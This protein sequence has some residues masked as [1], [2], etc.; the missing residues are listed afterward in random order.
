MLTPAKNKAFERFF[1]VYNRNLFRRR[2]QRFLVEG[3][4]HLVS[5]GEQTPLILYANHSSWWDGLA[6]F[7]ISRAVGLDAFVMM[8]ETQLRRYR[9]FRRLGAFSIDKSS[10]RASYRSLEF[11]SRLLRERKGSCLWI[12]PQGDIRPSRV[13]DLD[14]LG[15]I[16]RIALKTGKCRFV[17]V[18]IRYE[19]GGEFKPDLY[20]RAG[21]ELWLEPKSREESRELVSELEFALTETLAILDRR[22]A[23]GDTGSF[24]DILRR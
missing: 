15:G 8:D 21:P 22:I 14:F 3:T 13:D 11:A 5:G 20:T 12:F 2:F 24:E 6:A 4:E 7:E 18:A 10:V 23:D 17:P 19:F 16:G 9:A 1:A